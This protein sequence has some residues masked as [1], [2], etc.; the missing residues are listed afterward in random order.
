[1][2]KDEAIRLL[3]GSVIKTANAVGVTSQAVTQWPD[4]LPA[5]LSDR[6]LA[7]LSRRYVGESAVLAIAQTSIEHEMRAAASGKQ[8]ALELSPAN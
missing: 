2:K 7:A 1:M 6:V 5:R 3:G 4:D 8:R